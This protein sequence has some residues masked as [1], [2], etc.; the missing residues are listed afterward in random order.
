MLLKSHH[1]MQSEGDQHVLKTC[2]S[3]YLL[4]YAL[5]VGAMPSTDVLSA[6]ASAARAAVRAQS[7]LLAC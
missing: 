1:N 7:P 2:W 3:I 4:K 6:E 5:K